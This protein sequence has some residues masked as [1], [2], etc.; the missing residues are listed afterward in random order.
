VVIAVVMPDAASL[1]GITVH[2]VVR[3]RE[4]RA[5][6]VTLSLGISAAGK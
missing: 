1:R 3:R 6:D 4:V 5:L 2:L